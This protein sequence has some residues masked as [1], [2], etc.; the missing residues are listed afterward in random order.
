[1]I[2]KF[3]ISA[4]F[5]IIYVFSAELFPTVVRNVGVGSGSFWARVGGVVAPY[6]GEL[7]RSIYWVVKLDWRY[8]KTLVVK[9]CVTKWSCYP[10]FI[11]I[12]I[13][14]YLKQIKFLY[15]FSSFVIFLILGPIRKSGTVGNIRYSI[16]GSRVLGFSFTRDKRQKSPCNTRG[17]R[18]LWK[19][20]CTLGFVTRKFMKKNQNLIHV[21]QN[22]QL[23]S[24]LFFQK[25]A[26]SIVC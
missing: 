11:F 25:Q 9:L 3:C 8:H 18:E 15:T 6:I 4:S 10:N 16:A 24:Y 14:I 7:V 2:G 12:I 19:V 26:H 17:L 1:M 23:F 22:R 13:G 20:I 21:Q 5:A